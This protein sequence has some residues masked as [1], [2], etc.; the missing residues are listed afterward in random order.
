M[1]VTSL[2]GL[3]GKLYIYQTAVVLL[4]KIKLG[5]HGWHVHNLP[6]DQTVD[7]TMQCLSTVVGPH[8]DP[9]NAN[10]DSNYNTRCSRTSPEL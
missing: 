4:S 1:I 7:P 10:N 3:R 8:Y 5:S 6:V 2:E 9:F